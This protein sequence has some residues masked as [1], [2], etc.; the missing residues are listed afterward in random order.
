MT[1]NMSNNIT[2]LHKLSS[3]LTNKNIEFDYLNQ[4]VCCLAHVI[5]LA[6]Q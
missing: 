6:A 4:H 3:D 1:D 5:N 2:F